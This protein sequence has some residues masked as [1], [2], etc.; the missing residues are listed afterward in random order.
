MKLIMSIMLVLSIPLASIGSP[1]TFEFSGYIDYIEANENNALGNLSLNQP[2][3][4]WFRYSVVPDQDADTNYGYYGQ[5]ASISV[6]LGTLTLPYI[7]DYVYV[8]VGNNYYNN[9]EDAFV[10]VVDGGQGDYNFTKFGIYLFDSTGTVY[11]N[12]ALPV[13]FDLAQF[14]STRLD[15]Y[16]STS[17]VYNWFAVEGEITD[18]TFVPEPI[19]LILMATSFTILSLTRCRRIG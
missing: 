11:D 7:D 4:G 10:H 3:H 16:G 9:N 12:D 17:P 8:R 1:L 13:S 18:I 5:D 19:S 14:D 15:I 2:F 6:T